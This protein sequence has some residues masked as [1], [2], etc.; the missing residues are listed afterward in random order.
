MPGGSIGSYVFC[1][2]GVRR[3]CLGYVWICFLGVKILLSRNE[4]DFRVS[5]V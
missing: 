5:L 2:C 4:R 3:M 1:G